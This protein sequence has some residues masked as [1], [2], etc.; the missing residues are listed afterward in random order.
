MAKRF[1]GK[2]SPDDADVQYVEKRPYGGAKASKAGFGVNLLFVAP[3]PLVISMFVGTGAA[4]F[5]FALLALGMLLLAAWL[6]REGIL[7]QEAYD[8]RTVARKPAFPR[9]ICGAA[10]MGLGL[11]TAGFS[12][13]GLAAIIPG[14]AGV[15]LHLFAFG[16]D[17]MKNKG[18]DGIDQFQ[19]DRVARV[20]D[21]AESTLGIMSATVQNLG[22]RTVEARVA[23]FQSTARALFRRVEEDPTDLSAA[24]KYLSVYLTGAKDATQKF[25][26][27]YANKRDPKSRQEFLAFLDDLEGNFTAKTE[28]LLANNKTDL[29][30]EMKVLRDRLAREGLTTD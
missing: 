20:V 21:D 8:A 27:L 28:T 11:A 4:D 14:I 5:G 2:F 24:R 26:G 16:P 9:K 12:E 22:D 25:A 7:A 6:T 3:L 1:G 18:F 29:D 10:L 15:V 23:D 19:Q 30:I 17:P 13:M